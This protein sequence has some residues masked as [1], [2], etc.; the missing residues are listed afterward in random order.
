[1][2]EEPPAPPVLSQNVDNAAE[3]EEAH[4]KHF[5]TDNG[6]IVAYADAAPAVA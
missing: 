1:M 6:E 2:T 5:P 3:G 4:L